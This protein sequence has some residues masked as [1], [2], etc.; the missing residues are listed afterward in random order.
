[1]FV[2]VLD[3]KLK[4]FVVLL[5]LLCVFRVWL[6]GVVGK[7]GIKLRLDYVQTGLECF[8]FF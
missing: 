8:D 2:L 6:V 5:D 7:F 1:L 4:R 3:L